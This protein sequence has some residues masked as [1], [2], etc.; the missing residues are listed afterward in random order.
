MSAGRFTYEKVGI[1]RHYKIG[2][3]LRLFLGRE[4]T[5]LWELKDTGREARNLN[6]DQI[7]PMKTYRIM[8]G[9]QPLAAVAA[10]SYGQ[11]LAIAHAT[12]PHLAHLPLV[13]KRI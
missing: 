3:K 4:R 11:A 6:L 5:I 7:H 8:L 12:F 2:R 13:L 10:T 1:W 9:K